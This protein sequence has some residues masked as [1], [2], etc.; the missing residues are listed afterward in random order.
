M[1]ALDVKQGSPEWFAARLGIPTASMFGKIITPTG[2]KSSSAPGYM[3]QLLADWLAGRVLDAVEANYWMERGNELE[4]QA[5]DSYEFETEN[6]V[7]QVGFVYFDEDKQV[8]CSPD[9]LIDYIPPFVGDGL[10]E[11]KCPK[12]STLIEYY[13]NN[14]LPGKYKPQVQGQ[15]WITGRDWCDFY[16]FHPALNP[17]KIR[18]ERNDE[19]IETMSALIDE[20]NREMTTKREILIELGYKLEVTNA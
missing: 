6:K 5:R 7:Q 8:G 1:I 2:G 19:Y 18:V 14:Q 16:V 17:F 3:N 9:G 13:L 15:L 11:I 20:F 4:Q 12:A 10:L